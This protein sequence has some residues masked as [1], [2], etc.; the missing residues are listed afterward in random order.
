[1]NDDRSKLRTRVRMFTLARSP[2]HWVP[3]AYSCAAISGEPLAPGYRVY[4]DDVEPR[5][6]AARHG[7]A[8]V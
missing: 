6:R 8:V 4:W 3:V 7:S 2:C 1:M 5:S